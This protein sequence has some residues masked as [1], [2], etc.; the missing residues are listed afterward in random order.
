MYRYNIEYFIIYLTIPY[1]WTSLKLY[2]DSNVP[3]FA[4]HGCSG[5]GRKDRRVDGHG[6][7]YKFIWRC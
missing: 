5:N 3:S 2:V 1:S 4:S 7:S 6:K